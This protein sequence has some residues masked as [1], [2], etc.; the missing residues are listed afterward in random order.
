MSRIL[1]TYASPNDQAQHHPQGSGPLQE[2]GQLLHGLYR[3]AQHSGVEAFEQT[4]LNQ[5][6][7]CIPFDA[8]WIGRS[9]LTPAGPVMHHSTL[10]ALDNTY[11]N[12]WDRI[13][14]HDPLVSSV[15]GELGSVAALSIADPGLSDQ[16][17]A[18]LACYG[19]AQ[20]LCCAT[21]D[22]VL[23]TYL[24]V[25]LY[26]HALK[27]AFSETQRTLLQ[28]A[29]PNLA[30]ALSLNHMA[31]IE[32]VGAG[33]NQRQV[34][35]AL[36]GSDGV[37]VCADP[38]FAELMLLEWP[39]WPG[40]VVPVKLGRANGQSPKPR[41]QGQ[42]VSITS[43]SHGSFWVLRVR[44]ATASST[45]TPRERTVAMAFA[46]GSSYKEVARDLGMAPATVRHHLRQVYAKLHIQDKGSIAWMLSQDH[47]GL[48]SLGSA[49]H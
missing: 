45:L 27:P 17:R 13:R 39:E 2:L 31:E 8:A 22:P 21:C 24:H 7:S 49:E 29:L 18:F 4:V 20:V 6:S 19:I 26:R 11:L 10:H 23:Q 30:A 14:D 42:R 46:R 40:G 9:T 3:S 33:D 16:F 38:F 15:T 32:R 37:I 28:A 43:E 5:L 47:N 48:S 12:A 25:S 36:V 35:V 44:P 34:G 41:H 1:P